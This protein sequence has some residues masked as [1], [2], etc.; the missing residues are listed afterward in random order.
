M[1]NWGYINL[2]LLSIIL[3]HFWWKTYWIWA[4]IIIVIFTAFEKVIKM[5]LWK[6]TA[7]YMYVSLPY[8]LLPF[9]LTYHPCWWAGMV[10]SVGAG[11]IGYV[12]QW[13]RILYKLDWDNPIKIQGCVL[14]RVWWRESLIDTCQYGPSAGNKDTPTKPYHICRNKCPGHL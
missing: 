13:Q 12:A 10:H 14:I 9:F 7:R 8:L 5:C 1:W 3:L 11:L 6:T 2:F 4:K